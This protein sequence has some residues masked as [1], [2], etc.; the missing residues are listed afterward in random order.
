M[1]E[2][3]QPVLFDDQPKSDPRGDDLLGYGPFAERI[4]KVI[5][6]IEA[7][8]GYVIGLHGEWGS[9]KSTVLNFVQ[10]YLEELN[11][12][13]DAGARKVTVLNFQPWMVAGHQDLV[14]SFFKL[15]SEGLGNRP[16]LVQKVLRWFN[17]NTDNLVDAAATVGLTMDPTGG[18]GTKVVSTVAK[19]SIDNRL[20]RYVEEPSLQ[21]AHENLRTQL[22]SCG[23]RFLVTIDDLDRLDEGEV[24]SIMQMVKTVGSL[25][26]VTYVLAYDRRIVS[27]ALEGE[28][29]VEGPR[30][31]EKIVQQEVELPRLNTDDLLRILSGNL[32]FAVDEASDDMRW[33]YIV[34][35]GVRRWIRSPRDVLRLSNS[36][37]FCWS[38][39]EDDIDPQDLL[40][41]EGLR[42]FDAE[43]WSWIRGNRDFLFG[44]GQFSLPGDE[45]SLALAARLREGLPEVAAGQII[46]LLGTLFPSKAKIIADKEQYNHE[47]YPDV[48][49]RRGVGYEAGYDT[50]FALNLAPQAVPKNLI[51]RIIS[52]ISDPEEI[53][54]EI[55]PYL[56]E[57]AAKRGP[58][59]GTL[60]E[61]LRCQFAGANP[62]QPRQELLDAIFLIGEDVVAMDNSSYVFTL[63]PRADLGFVIGE[64][65][66][67]WGEDAGNHLVAA[68]NKSNSPV[69]CADILVDRGRELGVFPSDSRARALVTEPDFKRLSI[70]TH[71]LIVEAKADGTLQN[72]PFYF[73]IL[74][75]WAYVDGSDAPKGWIE[76]GIME[77]PEFLA[78]VGR[79]LVSYTIGSKP[80]A[81]TMRD[82]PNEEFYDVT[83]ILEAARKHLN[84]PQLSEDEA[85]LFSELERGC[86]QLLSPS[87]DPP[88]AD[89]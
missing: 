30:Y 54:E 66:E 10:A 61:E 46:R 52:E 81:Y 48:V 62:P 17:V 13:Q 72:A 9:G 40:A 31:M 2:E 42:L 85:N 43:V 53:A 74:K 18:A 70:R 57:D 77:S 79:G 51:D 86:A 68:F 4:A 36:L 23:R 38:S 24:R 21:K 39:L 3:A 56:I 26:G 59:I 37:A 64:M 47:R 71:E 63:S 25:P 14:A 49:K 19:T 89:L 75:S 34:R 73:D 76:N 22:K 35:D 60:L 6:S 50:Y 27:R 58:N 12:N 15:L 88:S 67:I 20:S 65:L 41:M 28:M 45:A 5:H 83:V 87:S 33:Y 7:P 29:D 55:R 16:T 1:K 11:E 44:A 32:P 8:N 78:K 84:D 82:A 69:F 80:R